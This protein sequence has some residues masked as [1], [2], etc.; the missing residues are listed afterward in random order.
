MWLDHQASEQDGALVYNW[1]A[2]DNLFQPGVLDAMFDAYALLLEQLA[3]SDTLWQQ[4]LP[5][6]LPLA[7]Q[8]VR[9]AIN[10]TAAPLYEGTLDGLFFQRAAEQPTA[11]ALVSSEGRWSYQQLSEWSMGIA[12][13]LRAAEVKPGDR[14]A[15][16]MHKGAAQIASC[17]AIQAT[18]AAYVPLSADTPVARLQTI[19]SG[20]DIRVLLTQPEYQAQLTCMASTDEHAD[21]TKRVNPL[22][23]TLVVDA[24]EPVCG[25]T[26]PVTGLQATDAAYV[27]YTSGST[28]VPKGVLIDHRGAVNTVLDINQRFGITAS[29]SV[30]G[31]SAL[32]FDLSVWDIFGTLAAGGTLVLPEADATRDPARWLSLIK[33]DNVTAWN[34]VP[35]LLDL[36]LAEADYHQHALAGLRCVFLSGDWI[37][38]NLPARLQHH[39]PEATLVAM[40]GATEASIW[41]NWFIVGEVQPQWNS[42]PY[43]YPLTNQAYHVLD[44]HLRD[45]PDYV[46]GD[47]F[48]AGCGVALGYENDAERTAASFIEHRGERLYR[49]GDLA[50]YW[51]DGTLE[52]LGR[53]D[54]QVKI[55]GNRI[56]L[57]EIEAALQQH[58]AIRDAVVDTIDNAHGEKRL[59]A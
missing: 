46:T 17:L 56:E 45:R 21:D 29:D 47:L 8:Q 38:L 10:D 44:C 49:T 23:V 1:D 9:Q 53:C 11:T 35:A 24:A 22:F 7:Q 30:I 41:S 20:S 52:F 14:V 31:L 51:P 4:P 25:D 40:G 59:A 6:L 26:L 39:A 28:G 34:S 13:Q 42:I 43:G 33:S 54:N 55:A 3:D 48:I 32:W 57:G 12:G 36:L 18:G 2:V 16:I 19:I 5:A 15:V 27:I 50:R 58:P 37:P